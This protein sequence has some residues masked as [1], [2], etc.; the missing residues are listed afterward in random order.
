RE[1]AGTP[2]KLREGFQPGGNPFVL[3]AR[4]S[5]PARSAFPER[6]GE[7]HVAVAA[8]PAN[9][10]VV[11]DTDVLTNRLWVTV[12]QFLGQEVVNPPFAQNGAFIFNAVD[13]L[14]GSPHLIAVRARAPAARRFE[15]VEALR[16]RAEE[17]YRATEEELQRELDRIEQE[18]IELQQPGDQAQA[19]TPAQEQQLVRFQE[20]RLR[21]RRELREV[22]RR[23]NAD[24]DGLGERLT[25]INVLAM[26][27]VVV[28]F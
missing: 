12:S 17:R 5:G 26:P 18:L 9:I 27:M 7:G 25:R 28:T 15:V 8:T 11:A 6:E 20:E 23:L 2:G 3:A 21:M 24:I 19:L 1:N 10:V 16:R 4:F 14:V 22:Q 13:N